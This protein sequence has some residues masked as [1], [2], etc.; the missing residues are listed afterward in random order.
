[1][2][3]LRT[4]RIEASGISDDGVAALAPALHSLRELTILDLRKNMISFKGVSALLAP[5]PP[6]I[7]ALANVTTLQLHTYLFGL[8]DY[9][10][11]AELVR[12]GRL[13]NIV[14]IHLFGISQ[15]LEGSHA[16]RDAV[17]RVVADRWRAACP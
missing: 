9:F 5:P 6:R 2:P 11:F 17:R 15:P 4:L 7:A 10:A 3:H 13:P 8:N 16:M 12:Q 1:M 14:D